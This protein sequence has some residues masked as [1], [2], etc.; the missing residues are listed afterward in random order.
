MGSADHVPH[1]LAIDAG[2]TG[3]RAFALGDDGT[4]LGYAYREFTQH[5]PRPGWVEHDAE[6][7]WA[8]TQAVCAEVVAA[9]GRPGRHRHHQPAR[10]RRG[11]EPDDRRAPRP[12]HRVAGPPHRRPLRR[13]RR[14]RPP[15][16]SCAAAPAWCS[17]RTS[18]GTK[19]AWLLTEG[20]VPTSDDLAVGTIDTWLV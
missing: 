11:V 9:H 14:R 19:I 8:T 18:P 1:V 13:P 16:H 7:I 15:R 3:V 5:F 2:T 20:G 10:D 17:T 12:G 6:E 4:P